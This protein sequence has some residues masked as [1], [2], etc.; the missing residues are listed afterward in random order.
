MRKVPM[1]A[2]ALVAVML[3]TGG[4]FEKL[5]KY[6]QDHYT[7][8]KVWFQDPKKESKAYFK[9]K[10]PEERDQW[11]KDAGYWDLFYKYD[12]Y[13]RATILS[14]DPKVGWKEDWL[15]MAWGQPYRKH[16][17]TKRTAE[18]SEIL[19]YRLEISKDG[20]VLVWVPGSNETYKAARRMQTEFWVDD[21]VVTNIVEKDGWEQ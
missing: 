20:D 8:L 13:D 14:R 6:E 10:T 19:T 12:E 11:L 2:A 17:S 18:R 3:G 21:G 1:I 15:F 4:K 16:K 5:Q 9:L 7:A